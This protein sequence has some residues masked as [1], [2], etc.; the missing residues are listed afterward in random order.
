MN[1]STPKTS[2]VG[3]QVLGAT[4]TIQTYKRANTRPSFLVSQITRGALGYYTNVQACKHETFVSG[5]VNYSWSFGHFTVSLTRAQFFFIRIAKYD[6]PSGRQAKAV[7][8]EENSA[9]CSVKRVCHE[10]VLYR[11]RRETHVNLSIEHSINSRK[12]Y[13]WRYC[14]SNGAPESIRFVV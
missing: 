1:V 7:T 11:K 3:G 2:N 14:S 13:N 9:L 4:G 6:V 5:I 12:F 10:I 8:A